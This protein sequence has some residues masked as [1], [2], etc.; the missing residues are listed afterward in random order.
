MS[1]SITG[2]GS[3]VPE[4]VLTNDDLAKMVD[5]SDEWIMQ[6]V[7]VS[8]R[9]IAV[10]ESAADM[11]IKAARNALENAN[12]DAKDIDLIIASTLTSDTACP[13]VA[14]Y[15]QAGVGAACPAFDIN[16]ACSGFLFALDT[17]AAFAARGFDKILVVGAERVSKIVNWTDRSTC[18]IFGD[19]AGAAVVTS[20]D[21]YLAS[22]LVTS[23]GDSVIKIPNY[24]GTSVFY[25]KEEDPPYIFMDGQETFKFAVNSIVDDITD[26]S[27]KAGIALSDIDHVVLHQANIRIMDYASKR[28]KIPKEKFYANIER[29]G[30]TS[31]ASVAI[32]LDEV[33]RS[34][35]LKRGD[36]VAMS[37]FG[38]GLSSAACILKW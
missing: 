28:L 36:I 35:N 31:S 17:A 9:H 30:N 32:A 10:N 7:G 5:T 18:V 15:V 21:G 11:A 3:Y 4:K 14:G 8:E 38:G 34:G 19:G 27:E 1:I 26:V 24:I 6:R 22:K 2:T 25:E 33:A 12:L 23:G 20:G 37:A 29:Y 13:T 16:S